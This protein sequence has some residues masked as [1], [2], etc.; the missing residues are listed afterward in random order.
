MTNGS[1]FS[2]RIFPG[3]NQYYSYRNY[4]FWQLWPFFPLHISHWVFSSHRW[5]YLAYCLSSL[6]RRLK[7]EDAFNKDTAVQILLIL[8]KPPS[9]VWFALRTLTND[10]LNVHEHMPFCGYFYFSC[11]SHSTMFAKN[12]AAGLGGVNTRIQDL[13]SKWSLRLSCLRFWKS[14][15]L[16]RLFWRGPALF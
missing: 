7:E 1:Q 3:W 4:F 5:S 11:C 2:K 13:L 15:N 12:T 10:N 14:G 6:P 9:C 8:F 16:T